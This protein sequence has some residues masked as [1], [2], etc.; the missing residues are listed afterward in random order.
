MDYLFAFLQFVHCKVHQI[1][2][3]QTKLW[4]ALCKNLKSTKMEILILHKLVKM[5][6][7]TSVEIVQFATLYA[8]AM[9]LVKSQ[10]IN[11]QMDQFLLGLFSHYHLS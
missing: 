5:G 8:I 4:R 3:S 11:N 9:K 7:F 6:M 1:L 2:F 10:I